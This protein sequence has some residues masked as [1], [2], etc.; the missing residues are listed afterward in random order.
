MKSFLLILSVTLSA[1]SIPTYAE[2]ESL[3]QAINESGRLRMLSQRM[4]KAY[5]LKA[6]DVQPAKAE[7]QYSASLNKFEQNLIDLR[8][9]SE[10]EQHL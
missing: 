4:A 8:A 1:I 5:L 6:M 10:H 2:I 7:K 9:F 3:S